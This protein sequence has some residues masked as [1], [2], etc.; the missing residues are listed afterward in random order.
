IEKEEL[1]TITS[2]PIVGMI[3]ENSKGEKRVMIHKEIHKFC[4][5]TLKTV[6]EKLKRYNKDVKYEYANPRPSDADVDYLKYYEE[7]IEDRLKHRD[8]MRCWEIYVNRR[9]L[10][11]RRGHPE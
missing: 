3:Y 7:D 10:R 11:S 5:A 9:P 8:Q 4:D 6:L 1:F 2:E